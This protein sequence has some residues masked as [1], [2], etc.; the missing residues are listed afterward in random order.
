[1]KWTEDL[2]ALL[3]KHERLSFGESIEIADKE[4]DYESSEDCV[5]KTKLMNNREL[6]KAIEST[7]SAEQ[8]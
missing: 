5:A 7:L 4:A 1:M 2:S 3:K 6:E 8:I